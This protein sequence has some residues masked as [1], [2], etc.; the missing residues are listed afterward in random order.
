VLGTQD[1][2]LA[3]MAMPIFGIGDTL[4]CALSIS[5]PLTR[6]DG[7]FLTSSKCLIVAAAVELTA[8]LGGDPAVF[9]T[10]RNDGADWAQMTSD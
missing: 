9:Q 8:R 7:E 1:P 4:V 6:F 2:D 3:G 5:G 10:L